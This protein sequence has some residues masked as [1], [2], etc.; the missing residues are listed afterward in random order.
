MFYKIIEN[1]FNEKD[2]NLFDI[3]RG[4]ETYKLDFDSVPVEQILFLCGHK[5]T[6]ISFLFHLRF[7]IVLYLKNKSYFSTILKYLKD[8]SGLRWKIPHYVKNKLENFKGNKQ[9]KVFLKQLSFEKEVHNENDCLCRKAEPDDIEH[10]AVAMKA[11]RFA[12]LKKRLENEQCLLLM[13]RGKIEH[14]FWFSQNSTG[15]RVSELRDD[16]IVLTGIDPL[17]LNAQNDLR[18]KKFSMI[19]NFLKEQKFSAV[20]SIAD[21]GKK[22]KEIFFDSLGFQ[23]INNGKS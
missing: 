15:S 13:N 23:K 19:S 8:I 6:F 4:D 12:E 20:L 7:K 1:S 11:K 14:Y 9:G 17:F 5:R 10:L 16:Q 18:A 2:I 21:S 3:G 22:Q